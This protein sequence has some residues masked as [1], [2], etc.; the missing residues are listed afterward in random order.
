MLKKINVV[1]VTDR[2]P[3]ENGDYYVIAYDPNDKDEPFWIEDEAEF[4]N[5]EWY[6]NYKIIAW[7]EEV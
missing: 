1:N 3:K 6:E 4:W 2:L 5:G 7:I